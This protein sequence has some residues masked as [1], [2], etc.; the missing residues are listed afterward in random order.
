[1][2]WCSWYAYYAEVTEQDIKEN[3]ASGQNLT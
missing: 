3:V 2:G 1:M